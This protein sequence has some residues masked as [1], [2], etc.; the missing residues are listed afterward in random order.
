M[1]TSPKRSYSVDENERF[2]LVFAKTVSII[3][4]TGQYFRNFRRFFF[5]RSRPRSATTSSAPCSW[6]RAWARGSAPAGAP[7]W[8]RDSASRSHMPRKIRL[9]RFHFPTIWNAVGNEKLHPIRHQFLKAVKSSLLK[10]QVSCFKSCIE[11]LLGL[12]KFF[13]PTAI[14]LDFPKLLLRNEVLWKL[15]VFG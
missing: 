15:F 1:K 3:S 7:W 5:V 11:G 4:G 8:A 6:Q 14:S 9:P 13:Y 10:T 2:G 12:Q